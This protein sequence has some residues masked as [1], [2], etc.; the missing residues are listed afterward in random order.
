M[1]NISGKTRCLPAWVQRYNRWGK[2]KVADHVAEGQYGRRSIGRQTV[3]GVFN[4]F[5][6][7]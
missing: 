7:S 5:N 1:R 3:L 6:L 4:S 2:T